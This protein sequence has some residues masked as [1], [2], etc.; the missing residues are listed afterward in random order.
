ML[1]VQKTL[2]ANQRH[3]VSAAIL[4]LRKL[5]VDKAYLNPNPI[6]SS[7]SLELEAAFNS[8]CLAIFETRLIFAEYTIYFFL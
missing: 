5:I 1:C 2:K 4:N 3:A 8:L 6:C 7:F